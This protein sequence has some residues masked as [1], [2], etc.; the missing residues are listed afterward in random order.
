M[1]WDSFLARLCEWFEQRDLLVPRARWVIGVSGGPDST[2]LLHAMHDLSQRRELRWELQVAHLHHGLRGRA[3]DD[4][5][6]FVEALARQLALAC[7]VERVHIPTEAAASGRS[8]EEVARQHRYKFLERVA[9]KTGS[10]GVAVA[11]HADD[12]AETIL[13]RIC[14]G[15]GMRGL[16]GMR[17]SRPIQPGSRVRLV[18]PFL[19]QRRATIEALCQECEIEFRT[20]S[21]NL[22]TDFT[23]GRIRNAVLP[24]LRKHLNPNVTEAL[25]RLGEQARW[26]ETYLQD[27]AARTFESLVVSDHPDRIVLNAP[28][29][30]S[31]QRVIQAEVI[32]RAVSLLPGGEQDPSFTHVEAVLRLAA[33]RASGKELHLPGPVVVQKVYDRLEFRPPVPAETPAELA[34]VF[35]ACPGTTPLPQLDAEL[36]AEVCEVDGAKIDEL[37]RTV[38]PYEEWL[39]YDRLQPPLL[40]RGRRAGDRFRPL[41]APGTKSLSEFFIDEKIEP[42][43]RA[44]TGVLCDQAG[45]VWVMPLRIDERVKLRS[46]SRRALR[47]VL[48]PTSQ[49]SAVKS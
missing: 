3:A 12:N 11:H 35:V 22:N 1:N 34:P 32:R 19:Q 25:L 33:E 7:H 28:A 16:A 45:V 21:T 8:T 27:A 18:R 48:T 26:L 30:L 24:M 20:D 38:N 39:D 14:R 31:K 2:L 47:L 9:L 13:H 49:G 36:T 5:A 42:P 4:D 15:T 44:R 6:E 40:V 41:G 29:L 23:R 37:R 17:D 46:N 43:L 10:D